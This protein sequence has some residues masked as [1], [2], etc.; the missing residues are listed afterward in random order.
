MRLASLVFASALLAVAVPAQQ[1][2]RGLSREQMW[3]APSAEDW[4]RPVLLTFQRTWED[5]VAVAQE[6]GRP[7]LICVNMDGEIASEHYAGIRYRQPEI[8]QLYEPYVLVVASVYRHTIRDYDGEGR[9]ILCPRFGS[10]TCGEHIRIEPL[11]YDR[12]FEGVRVAPR[13]IMV[14]LD[15]AETYDVYYAFDTDSVFQTIRDGIADRADVPVTVVRG[16]RP[17]LERV[18]SRDVRD[19]EA[20]EK[21]YAEGDSELQRAL[22]DAAARHPEAEP[23][24]LLRLALS[25]FDAE[26]SRAAR[27]AL[28]RTDS[29]AAVDLISEE[30][31]LS[32]EQSEREGL[33]AALQR[34]GEKSPK[35]RRLAVVH[36]GLSSRSGKVDVDG[37]SSA[38]AGGATYAPRPD[39]AELETRVERRTAGAGARPGD[40]ASRLALAEASLDLAVDPATGQVL[41]TDRRT[42]SRYSRLMFEDAQRVAREAEELGA[43]GWRLHAVLALS[44]YYLGDL[45]EAHARAEAAMPDIP[46]GAEEWMAIA[47]LALFAQARQEA[48]ATAVREKRDWPG[49]WLTDVHAAYSVIAKHPLGTE[50][51]VIAHYDFLKTLGGSGQAAR[52]LREGL[53]RFP[54]SGELH[55]RWRVSLLEEGGVAGMEEAYRRRLSEEDAPPNLGWFAG[56]ASIIAAEHHRRQR[57][58]RAALAAYDRGIAFFEEWIADF[59][60]SPD[61]ADHQIALALAGKARV[62]M[63]LRDRAAAVEHLLAS[64]RRKP[65]AA[66]SRD[67]LNLSPVD[68]ANMLR[69]RLEAAGEAELLAQVQAAL[70]EL[71][72]LDPALLEL[73]AF[74]R[75][76]APVVR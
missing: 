7:I 1:G 35:A 11:L 69:A 5:A 60:E 10:V 40:A 4:E 70:D 6:T 73:P 63:L 17:L 3:P 34:I 9:R 8:A 21:A 23:H 51:H 14:E 38:I 64:F 49:E 71:K 53:D 26:L 32:L 18:Q 25:G 59:P 56:Y 2:Q 27:N 28:A 33:L 62:A 47:T 42:A 13:H 30:L 37:W 12:Y 61:S 36:R 46:A 44:S 54:D 31:G 66:A 22:L 43:D 24:D 74:E 65:E 41:G 55:L 39:W 19:R 48:I 16:D 15:G 29:A 20:V 67:G 50:E 72:A 75:G 68:T 76:G 57:D 45:E 52:V 58:G